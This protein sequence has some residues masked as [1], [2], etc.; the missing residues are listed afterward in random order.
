LSPW[1]ARAQDGQLSNETDLKKEMADR[2]NGQRRSELFKG[3]REPKGAADDKYMD[4][5]ARWYVHRVSLVQAK[6][7]PNEMAKLHAELESELVTPL[8]PSDR[9]PAEGGPGN[10]V[11][12]QKLGKPL[13]DRLRQV[14]ALDLAEHRLSVVNAAIMLPEIAK[15]KQEDVGDLLVELLKDKNRHD[16]V[17]L[18]AAKA[19]R[20]FFPAHMVNFLDK[21][22]DK[23][24]QL[25]FKRDSDR[26]DAL[27]AFMD[28]K[29]SAPPDEAES[30]V[31]R[32]LRKEAVTSLG[33]VGVPALW[34]HKLPEVKGPAA[35]HLLRVL[36]KGKD[37]YQPAPSL[38]ERV[39]A[40]LGLCK[41]QDTAKDVD[42]DPSMAVYAIG[43][44]FFDFASEYRADHSVIVGRKDPKAIKEGSKIPTLPWKILSVRFQGAMKDLVANTN[45]TPA[46]ANA[47][48]LE[49][50]VTRMADQMFKY[51]QVE[52]P[53]VFRRGLVDTI[54][55]KTGKL[56]KMKG[57][58][59]DP[60]SLEGGPAESE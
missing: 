7:S 47:Q 12:V 1:G 60:A 21:K 4:L 10:K 23:D 32:Y 33:H 59:I 31:I 27:V 11:F 9:P 3:T 2:A 25:R 6:T 58:E 18:Y 30:D 46:Y 42:Y 56:Y 26:L 53:S 48:R 14:F 54:K 5:L 41:L 44:C 8:R 57:P 36:V 39:E 22:E 29:P 38:A 15:L 51:V 24:F 55:P 37:G 35:Y 50:E 13:A 19:M 40:A 43:L 16:A 49:K 52:D 20:E 17:K 45:K 28:R 34:S